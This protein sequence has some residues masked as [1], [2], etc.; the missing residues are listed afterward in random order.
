MNNQRVSEALTKVEA[1]LEP[2][3]DDEI[4]EVLRRAVDEYLSR[5]F[6]SAARTLFVHQL[7]RLLVR[8]L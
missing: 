3:A 6:F 2:L 4:L 1:A 7:L 8:H 5:L